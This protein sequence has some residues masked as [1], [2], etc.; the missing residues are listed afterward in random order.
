MIRIKYLIALVIP[1]LF[2]LFLSCEKANERID[3]TI[4]VKD[5]GNGKPI[6]GAKVLVF[7][8]EPA[9]YN[10]ETIDSTAHTIIYTDANG[11]AKAYFRART[12]KEYP[13][14]VK[15]Y[16]Y[17]DSY[18][19]NGVYPKLPAGNKKTMTVTMVARAFVKLHLKNSMPYDLNDSINIPGCSG[20]L[21]GF[22]GATVDT[23]V[24]Y[25][26]D[27]TCTLRATTTYSQL[28]YTV[29]R[30]SAATTYSFG[31][32]TGGQNDTVTVNINY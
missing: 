1:F 8:T 28:P 31:F 16:G 21:Y 4:T 27:C 24:F 19:S 3:C 23:T 25:C 29:I 12:G 15:Q 30:N 5:A 10:F 9:A 14:L 17:L 22:K 7:E 18:V 11:Q 2:F 20:K 13:I 6:L 26:P 32:T